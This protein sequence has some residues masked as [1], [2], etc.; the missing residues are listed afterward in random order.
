MIGENPGLVELAGV[1]HLRQAADVAASR[2]SFL[3]HH[4]VD[5]D[6]RSNAQHLVKATFVVVLLE[7]LGH[8]L[9]PVFALRCRAPQHR[10]GVRNS[11]VENGHGFRQGVCGNTGLVDKDG[12]VGNRARKEAGPWK[13]HRFIRG[14]TG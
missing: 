1:P 9:L 7:H 10:D 4:G 5:H 2:L 12:Q 14:R 3:K 13:P 8:E 11:R 6:R